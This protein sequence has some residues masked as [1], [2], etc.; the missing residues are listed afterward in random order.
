MKNKSL[1]NIKWNG[2]FLFGFNI[3]LL[4]V[5]INSKAQEILPPEIKK[6]FFETSKFNNPIWLGLPDE[7]SLA[8]F[9]KISNTPDIYESGIPSTTITMNT[10]NSLE[11]YD[12]YFLS[13]LV[14]N[15]YAKIETKIQTKHSNYGA[16]STVYHFLF[17]SDDF[18]KN[19]HYYNVSENYRQTAKPFI[20]LAHRNLISIDYKNQ[21]EDAPGGMKRTFYSITF[22]YKLVN[23][24]T[25]LPV[26]NRV[27]KGKG[28]I[29]KDPDDGTWKMTGPFENL[30]IAL[31]DNDYSEFSYI[32]R[33]NYTA[34]KFD[35]KN[36]THP[37][38]NT[39]IQNN[40]NEIRKN[41]GY[42]KD[43]LT[44]N[45][46]IVVNKKSGTK[47]STKIIFMFIN[48]NDN[49][50]IPYQSQL[51]QHISN[52]LKER[53]KL[54]FANIDSINTDSLFKIEL[55]FTEKFRSYIYSKGTFWYAD[56]Q[57][58]II[59]TQNGKLLKEKSFVNSTTMLK[60]KQDKW[61]ALEDAI[62]KCEKRIGDVLEDYVPVN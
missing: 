36:P 15:G 37:I 47:Q 26:I 8:Q 5:S 38:S 52:W 3:L 17:Y 10:S 33:T 51:I 56:L 50:G 39:N 44:G 35:D 12:K 30:G 45:T 41:N 9:Q 54:S 40:N 27:F 43:C 6:I 13:F 60:G 2:E 14:K 48:E 31:G 1:L 23:D 57:T 53:I 28:K 46:D 29:F 22:S 61:T 55:G 7:S 24:L 62:P 21:Y 58:T 19:I 16:S 25:N 4:L 59:I 11:D 42:I 32:V 34:F 18:K 20:Q 49:D